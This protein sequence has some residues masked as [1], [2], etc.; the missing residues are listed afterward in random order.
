M[1]GTRPSISLPLLSDTL[2]TI[3]SKTSTSLDAIADSIADKASP[4]G[5]TVNSDLSFSGNRAT[6][7]GAVLMVDGAN[8]TAPGAMYYDA[9]EFYLIDSTGVIQ[10]TSLGHLNP[11]GF[12]G[13]G[14]D[15]G[16]PNPALVSYNNAAS[17]YRF[18]VNP[19]GP[20]WAGVAAK[21]LLLEGTNGTV[22]VGVDDAISGNKIANFKSL[23]TS[24]VSFLAYDA[25]A[26]A[27]VDGT[28]TVTNAITTTNAIT[29][30][31]FH[32]TTEIQVNIPASAAVK[33]SGNTAAITY[34]GTY[35]NIGFWTFGADANPL[36]F[37]VRVPVGAVITSYGARV[38]KP[39]GTT[40]HIHVVL[41]K[42]TSGTSSN[43][44]TA[45]TSGID[46]NQNNPG[47]IT[48]TPTSVPTIPAAGSNDTYQLVVYVTGSASID[49]LY[50]P[51]YSYTV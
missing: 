24:G 30:T 29:A 7:V 33:G 40:D 8:P 9:G 4:S 13:I 25:S 5:L 20:V 12:G 22:K 48:I 3:V 14:G 2:S 51:F 28:S 17:E 18:Y 31:V 37:D 34:G 50:N 43:P 19:V 11:S 16:S 23:P 32:N 6:D 15:Y 21:Y 10:V 42:V 39:S 27:I 45:N 1:I 47:T 26:N 46:N 36:I 35:G 44:D 38:N 49:V 41:V